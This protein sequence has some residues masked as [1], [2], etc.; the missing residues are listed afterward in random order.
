[1]AGA[2]GVASGILDSDRSG[3]SAGSFE[4]TGFQP[5][6]RATRASM[7]P[8]VCAQDLDKP[9]CKFAKS[10]AQWPQ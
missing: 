1:M 3:D 8:H 5:F 9:E 2:P 6:S 4:R 7:L 10:G